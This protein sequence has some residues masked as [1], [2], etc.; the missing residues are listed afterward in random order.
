MIE[1]IVWD[2][3]AII[4]VKSLTG[5]LRDEKSQ[6]ACQKSLETNEENILLLQSH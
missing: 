4:R 5:F 1:N 2:K 3:Q 6:N